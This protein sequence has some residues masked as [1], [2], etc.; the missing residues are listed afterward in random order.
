[1]T[2]EEDRKREDK[3]VRYMIPQICVEK[4]KVDSKTEGT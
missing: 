4:R 3:E 1:M 2:E